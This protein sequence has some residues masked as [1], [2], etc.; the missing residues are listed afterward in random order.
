[1]M[2]WLIL[3]AGLLSGS[4]E[5]LDEVTLQLK[6]THAFQFAGYYAAVEQGYYRDVGLK[7]K[8]VEAFPA[9]HPV[10]EV[11]EGRAQYGVGSSALLLERDQGRPVV[12]LAVVFQQSPYEIYAAPN[13]RSLHD[14]IGKR[15]MLEPQ[16]GELLAF[17]KKE[18]VSSESIQQL[19]HSF[20]PHDLMDGK[21]DAIAGYVSNEPYTFRSAHYP[22]QT[23]SPRSVGIDFYGDNLFTSEQEL[24]AHPQRAKAFRAASMRG[25]QYAKE[26]RDEI[27]DLIRAKYAPYLTRESLRFESDQ[28]IPLLQPNLIEIGYMNPNRWRDIVQTYQDI[29]LLS[30]DFLLDG[31]LYDAHEADLAGVNRKLI[32]ALLVVSAVALLL[33]FFVRI[34][35]KLQ[36]SLTQLKLTKKALGESEQHYRLLIEN[37]HDV[38][39]ILDPLTLRFRWVSDSIARLRGYTPE[40]IMRDPLGATMRAEDA[41]ALQGQLKIDLDEFHSG[42]FPGKMYTAEV[43]QSC[44]DG[45]IIWIEIRGRF[46]R[47][48]ATGQVELHGITRDI[49]ERKTADEKIQRLAFYDALS[50]LP[51]RVLL[52]DR[53]KQ[54]LSAAKRNHGRVALMFID[55]DRFKSI[56]DTLG[57][58]VGDELLKQAAVRMSACVRESDTVARIGGDE[59]IV[60]LDMLDDESHA[61]AVAEKIR[62]AMVLPFSAAGHQLHISS[63]IGVAIYPQHGRSGIELAKHADI[64]MYQAKEGGRDNVR[65]FQLPD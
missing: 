55:L 10:N 14:L 44:K 43:Q 25:W 46:H 39:W 32:Y 53:L 52:N 42:K 31:F 29:G 4:A 63:S 3:I 59:F 28:M 15:I 41:A 22:Y 34:N 7:V 57:H 58:D 37:M 54:S 5:A 51:N 62:A 9:T 21:V 49:S 60:L 45:S 56:N 17:L 47:D 8:I 36:T 20:N 12:A 13:I 16:T 48:E 11:L 61:L 50:G 64:A 30:P 24:Q 26:H 23:F 35:R 38:V 1:M 33:V 40:E 6:W 2:R 18:G 19:P 65:L 27:F